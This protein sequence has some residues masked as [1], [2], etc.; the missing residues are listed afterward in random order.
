MDRIPIAWSGRQKPLRWRTLNP[1]CRP[2]FVGSLFFSLILPC[3]GSR[4]GGDGSRHWPWYVGIPLWSGSYIS[5]HV[6]HVA[7]TSVTSLV[8]RVTADNETQQVPAPA[9]LHRKRY[10]PSSC[11]GRHQCFVLCCADMRTVT[12]SFGRGYHSRLSKISVWFQCDSFIVW[13]LF[14]MY[15]NASFRHFFRRAAPARCRDCGAAESLVFVRGANVDPWA[16]PPWRGEISRICGDGCP[17]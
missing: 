6:C 1:I 5:C 11:S 3:H 17:A 7:V 10:T 9:W 15:L 16:T 12:L 14:F 8:R 2:L 4:L 13:N